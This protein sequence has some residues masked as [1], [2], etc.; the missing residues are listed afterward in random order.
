VSLVTA[1]VTSVGVF[2]IV[3]PPVGAQQPPADART[4]FIGGGSQHLAVPDCIPRRADAASAEACAT[5]T[6]VLRN[7]IRFEG[8]FPFVP[9][10]LVKSLP[11]QNPDSPNFLDWQGINAKILVMTRAEV[12]GAEMTVEVKAYFVDSGQTMMSRRYTGK[13]DNPRIFAHSASDEIMERT[14]YRGVAKSKIAFTSDRDSKP[15]RRSKEIYIMDYDGYNPRRLTVSGS[16]NILPAWS[17]DGRSLLYVSYRQGQPVVFRASIYE[18]KSAANVT[19]EKGSQAFAPS[20]SPDGTRM[21]FASNRG[22]NMDVWVANVDGSSPRRLTQTAAADTAPCWS[23]TGQEIAF[24]SGRA[25]TPQLWVM[26]AEGLNVRRLTTIG[27]YNDG[28]AWSPSKAES[29]IAYTSRLESGG[30]DIAVVNLATRQ[31]RQISQGRGSCEYPS[32][33]PSGRHL[34]FSCNRGG[35]WQINVANR[36]GSRIQSIAAGPGNNVQP[37]WGP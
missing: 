22:G 8:L 5:I 20:I 17:P 9:E 31:V 14:Q 32:W 21:A 1:L 29:E 34:A 27:N 10:S 36:D 33:A 13:A 2:A 26:D 37:D 19:G 11:P 4:I 16:L 24:T 18:G 23:P 28:C 15:D 12:S 35:R 7:D 3:L 30:F 6:E 25:G